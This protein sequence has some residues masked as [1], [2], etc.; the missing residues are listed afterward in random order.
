MQFLTAITKQP[1]SLTESKKSV[2]VS[3]RWVLV[4]ASSCLILFNDKQGQPGDIAQIIVLLLILS[5]FLIILLPVWVFRKTYFD[6]LLV[7]SDIALI[8]ISV[9]MTDQIHSD[10]FFLYFL[11]I[12]IAALSETTKSLL[13]SGS[14]VAIVYLIMVWKLEGAMSLLR[15]DILIRVPFLLMVTI[16]YGHLAQRVRQEKGLVDKLGEAVEVKSEYLASMTHEV[17]TPMNSIIGFTELLLN[18]G[19]GEVATQQREILQR[20]SENCKHL[21][22]L[23]NNILDL[24]K[25]EARAF[26][27]RLNSGDLAEFGEEVVDTCEALL[28]G[29]DIKLRAAVTPTKQIVTD[30]GILRQVALNLLSNAIKFTDHGEVCLIL[31]REENYL[32]LSVRDTGIGIKESDLERLFKP[33]NQIEN[34]PNHEHHIGTGLGLSIIKRQIELLGGTISVESSRGQGTSFTAKIPLTIDQQ[35]TFENG[36]GKP[37]DSQHLHQQ[38]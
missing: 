15:T 31:K 32:L 36:L 10:F 25:L 20:I 24:S 26:K 1:S 19:Y 3:L 2:I 30:W 27:V 21:L 6:F 38:M 16:F 8:S 11:V 9:W 35:I 13:L 14:I 28:F 33:Y 7:C 23:V 37:Q 12:M 4:I 17:R 34:Q 5:N 29:K 22:L 18:G